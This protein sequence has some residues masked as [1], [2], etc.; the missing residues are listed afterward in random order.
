MSSWHTTGYWFTSQIKLFLL[1]IREGH[2]IKWSTCHLSV[3]C[4]ITKNTDLQKQECLSSVL[5]FVAHKELARMPFPRVSST[6]TRWD[7]IR[8]TAPERLRSQLGRICGWP[9]LQTD[10]QFCVPWL[11]SVSKVEGISSFAKWSMQTKFQDQKKKKIYELNNV[12]CVQKPSAKSWE[13][14]TLP[15]IKFSG[16]KLSAA[17]ETLTGFLKHSHNS[18]LHLKTHMFTH[19]YAHVCTYMHIHM[20]IYRHMQTH[21]QCQGRQS[22]HV[23]RVAV[24]CG[25]QAAGW[26][27]PG[28]WPPEG[29][30]PPGGRTSAAA[31]FL[32]L[33]VHCCSLHGLGLWLPDWGRAPAKPGLCQSWLLSL[34]PTQNYAIS[35]NV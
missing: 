11:T 4:V 23:L 17:R 2:S 8:T 32:P 19:A 27:S 14:F 7:K 6:V 9:R 24:P 29:R 25:G 26:W 22:H 30:G 13:I 33:E 31:T 20:H 12:Q 1:K 3:L 16:S 21:T 34:K 28:C 15:R 10:S 5:P 18:E 35:K